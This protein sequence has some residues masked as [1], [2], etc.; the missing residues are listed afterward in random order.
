MGTGS[1]T[2]VGSRLVGGSPKAVARSKRVWT[3]ILCRPRS[4]FVID[5]RPKPTSSLSASCV[6]PTRSRAARM[7]PPMA[8]Y[9]STSEKPKGSFKEYPSTPTRVNEPDR[10]C[11]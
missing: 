3:V 1:A 8:A 11:C 2:K 9:N 5:V 10:Q 7:R 4:M 6:R